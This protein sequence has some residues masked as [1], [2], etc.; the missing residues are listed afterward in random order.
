MI[1]SIRLRPLRIDDAEVMSAVLADPSLYEFTG[2][3][4]PPPD[5]LA[6]QYAVQTRGRSADGT[7]LWI[8]SIVVFGAEQTPIGYVQATRPVPGTEAEIAWVIGRP[9]QGQGY[10]ARATRLLADDLVEQGVERLVAHIHPQ[11]AASHRVAARLGMSPTPTV[12]DGEVRWE[13]RP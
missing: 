5:A 2:G 7:E 9:W 6:G 1:E 10:A 8:N 11:H 12:V 3:E 13:G 4:P